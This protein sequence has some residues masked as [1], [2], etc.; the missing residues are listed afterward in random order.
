MRDYFAKNEYYV[1]GVYILLL[2]LIKVAGL[3]TFYKGILALLAMGF[4]VLIFLGYFVFSKGV[5]FKILL[6]IPII[7]LVGGL[8]KI[9]HLPSA[10][11]VIGVGELG[12]LVFSFVW[13]G[14]VFRKESNSVTP[15]QKI[16]LILLS[17]VLIGDFLV[18]LFYSYSIYNPIKIYQN[19]SGFILAFLGLSVIYMDV[20]EKNSGIM[21]LVKVTTILSI[22]GVILSL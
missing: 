11:V 20:S 13:M 4:L 12:K 19:Y 15:K 9:M 8:M 7:I 21:Y 16:L 6:T 2:I 18:K 14:A 10:G 1:L 3:P 22:T 17:L 5:G